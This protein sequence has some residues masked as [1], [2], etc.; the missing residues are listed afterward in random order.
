QTRTRGA[1]CDC[2]LSVCVFPVTHSLRNF[3]TGVG[4][5]RGFPEFTAVGLVDGQEFIRYDSD[6]QKA[7]PKTEWIERNV[8]KD[9]WDGQT[10]I[11]VGTQPVFK[12]AVVDLPQRFNQSAGVHTWQNMYGCELD[13]DGTTRGFFQFGYDGA[14]YISLDKSTL[15]WTAANQR[16]MT[17]KLK[18]DPL[19]AEN[20]RLKGY[21]ENTCIEWLRKY[22]DYGRETLLRTERPQVSVS[23]KDSRLGGTE[24]TCLATGFFPKDVTVSWRRDGQDLQE[25]VDS[26]EVVPN[27]DGSFQVRKSLRVRAGEE[28]KYSCHVDHKSLEKTIV[29]HWGE[30]E[31]VFRGVG[32]RGREACSGAWSTEGGRRVQGRGVQRE[33]GVFRGVGYRGREAC[34]GVWGTV[35]RHW[36]QW[37][38]WGTVQR[39]WGRRAVWGTVQRHWGQRVVCGGGLVETL[40][41]A[42]CVR[43]R[44]TGDSGLCAVGVVVRLLVTSSSGGLSVCP[45]PVR[46]TQ[47]GCV[48]MAEPPSSS[49]V[50]IIAA[51]CA[52]V[53]LAVIAAVAVVLVRRR[54]SSGEENRSQHCHCV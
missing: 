50:P 24:L 19:T 8:D 21:L 32:Y 38:V 47:A 48:S 54:K 40:G 49:L 29:Q 6:S 39:H 37:A 2:C 14:D 42:G 41:T 27:G 13:D 15:T 17:T 5:V 43:Y 35:Q 53:A 20:Q 30:R 33:G 36:G 45:T 25:D 7:V 18:W 44:D 52:V 26:G 34:S 51:V 4:G 1:L 22:V 46:V 16:A 23:H 9:Y 28:D 3:F 12:V 10:Q 11:A 31:G